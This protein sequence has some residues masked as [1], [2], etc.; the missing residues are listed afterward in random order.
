MPC[1]Q[2]GCKSCHLNN[3]ACDSCDSSSG[4]FLNASTC[5]YEADIQP[6]YGKD[7]LNGNLFPCSSVGCLDCEANFQDCVACDKTLNIYLN[8]SVCVAEGD[9][10]HGW[11]ID[12]VSGSLT[13]CDSTGCLECKLDY[14]TCTKCDSVNGDYLFGGIC[15]Q[16]NQ[17]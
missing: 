14:K 8:G 10:V 5:V 13:S 2:T 1:A 12:S 4:Y 16:A 6:K 7:I 17:I 3:A 9:I 15:I 11:G